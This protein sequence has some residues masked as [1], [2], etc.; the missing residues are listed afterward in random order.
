MSL[1]A[2]TA[3]N[4][5]RFVAFGPVRVM[6]VHGFNNQGADSYIQLHQKIPDSIAAPLAT[7]NV[8]TF[9]SLLAQANNGFMYSFLP[10][11]VLLSQLVYGIS[12]TEASF[13]AVGAA[14]AV[15]CTLDVDSLYLTSGGET[16]TGDL[17]T[18]VDS[19]APWTDSVA[20]VANRLLRVDY[21][22]HDG[23]VRY[24]LLSTD[25]GTT[26]VPII[27]NQVDSG[28]TLALEFGR[29]GLQC[30]S[31]D[32][33]YAG[34]YGCKILQSTTVSASGVTSSAASYIKALWR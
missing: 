15:D 28:G 32:A 14:A 16:I 30:F 19:I 2:L 13:T 29:Q 17:T 9:K 3:A 4:I 5:T 10:D 26:N 34:H 11:G 25:G 22:N 7:G 23:A 27:S 31:Q 18:G 24:L 20:N 6:R 12:S 8:P 21:Q 33:A 1:I